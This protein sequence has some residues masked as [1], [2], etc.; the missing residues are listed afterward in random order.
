MNANSLKFLKEVYE[1]FLETNDPKYQFNFNPMRPDYKVMAL[2]ALEL[3]EDFG[4]LECVAPSAG[5]RIVKLTPSGLRYAESGYSDSSES[6]DISIGDNSNVFFGSNNNVV[7]SNNRI[8]IR[9]ISEGLSKEDLDSLSR[10]VK[11][12]NSN[13]PPEKKYHL[14][15]SIISTATHTF[16]TDVLPRLL[17]VIPK[18]P[19]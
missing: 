2:N 11:E 6:R 3:L 8:S 7:N 5:F 14:I 15:K 17:S 4:Y 19:L 1:H 18:L 12:V 16:V 13:D 10:V 9:D